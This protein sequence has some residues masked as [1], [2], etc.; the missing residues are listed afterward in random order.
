NQ[1]A[2]VDID[3]CRVDGLVDDPGAG[4]G[5]DQ[6]GGKGGIAQHGVGIELVPG[7]GQRQ[8]GAGVVSDLQIAGDDAAGLKGD[9]IEIGA[10][11]KNVAFEAPP[12][13]Q[14]GIAESVDGAL[15]G[16]GGAGF[17]DDG[18]AAIG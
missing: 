10:G 14:R 16:N 6:L 5:L 15:A 11:E 8:G 1:G 18:A 12:V 3:D 7:A 9:G 4:A 13:D 17:V 2:G